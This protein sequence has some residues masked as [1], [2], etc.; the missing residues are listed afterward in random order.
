MIIFLKNTVDLANHITNQLAQLIQ[1][2]FLHPLNCSLFSP[3]K[4][5]TNWQNGNWISVSHGL[6]LAST[7]GMEALY[8]VKRCSYQDSGPALKGKLRQYYI[9]AKEVQWNYGPSGLDPSTGKSLHEPNRWVSLIQ[10]FKCG[11]QG[12]HASARYASAVL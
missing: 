1:I 12:L 2:L 4:F 3:H 11:F 5:S 9:A 7:A 10:G 8:E 6:F